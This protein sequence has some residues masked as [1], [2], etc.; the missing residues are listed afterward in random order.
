MLYS[1]KTF[2]FAADAESM[3]DGSV[4][5]KIV[6]EH[7]DADGNP[8]GSIK[9]TTS[10]LNTVETETFIVDGTPT[11]NDMF[12]EVTDTHLVTLV[13]VMQIDTK[14][15]TSPPPSWYA[16][17]SLT[18][19][20]DIVDGSG[21]TVLATSLLSLSVADFGGAWGDDSA[22]ALQ[23]AVP[24]NKQIGTTVARL[25][26][27]ITS[28][29]TGGAIPDLV[30]GL[31]NIKL[32]AYYLGSVDPGGGGTG[33]T[34]DGDTD[35]TNEGDDTGEHGSEGENDAP[36]SYD[37]PVLLG[38]DACDE[39]RWDEGDIVHWW[40]ERAVMFVHEQRVYCSMGGRTLVYDTA[41]K[42][43]TDAGL[44]QLRNA[45]TIRENNQPE[46]MIFNC[47]PVSSPDPLL[48]DPGIAVWAAHRA[49]THNDPSV[50]S[51][52]PKRIVMPFSLNREYEIRGVRLRVFGSITD[53]PDA[54]SSEEIGTLVMRSDSGYHEDYPIIPRFFGASLSVVG[55]PGT[56]V[57]QQFSP[58]MI[59]RILSADL[60]FMRQCVTLTRF[61]L[62]Y[63]VVK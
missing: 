62:D 55:T 53:L 50:F 8:L 28:D 17:T 32:R 36:P 19:T 42:G 60:S 49:L 9:V 27:S 54:T 4:T 13:Q 57:D 31:D 15:I 34:G 44:G 43:W 25:K 20:F 48:P 58:A 30:F 24:V 38:M 10:G 16:D 5:S 23:I 39:P 12:S 46:T 45:F 52:W 7:N 18:L 6:C 1:D 22:G 40:F 35:G 29:V 3:L 33:S 21:T 56:I 26:L 59:G 63:T 61:V 14:L 11:W 41:T 51:T 2:V 37:P 47:V